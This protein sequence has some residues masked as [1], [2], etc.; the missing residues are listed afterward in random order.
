MDG[1]ARVS[2]PAAVRGL[3]ALLPPA[4]SHGASGASPPRKPVGTGQRPS[5]QLPV[6]GPV[7][8]PVC[9]PAVMGN[10]VSSERVADPPAA[11][12]R[13][14][15]APPRPQNTP[16]PTNSA[17]FCSQDTQR[18][19]IC[20]YANQGGC[21]P[22]AGSTGG[23]GEEGGPRRTCHASP[24]RCAYP[25][26]RM[27]THMHTCTYTLQL[28]T[29]TGGAPD[30]GGLTTA[31]KMEQVDVRQRSTFLHQVGNLSPSPENPTWP[32][33]GPCPLHPCPQVVA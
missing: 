32:E 18:S 10:T 16:D 1:P 6:S 15:L 3:G 17:P 28:N 19:T 27:H 30:L 2:R 33:Q 5:G 4:R 11:L 31:V 22:A 20:K 25:H 23:P 7:P 29:S 8:T 12:A 9:T 24:D 26:T 21:P 13:H 14:D